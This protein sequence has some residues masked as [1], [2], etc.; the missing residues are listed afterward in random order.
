MKAAIEYAN[1]T[2]CFDYVCI[3]IFIELSHFGTGKMSKVKLTLN[4]V[5]KEVH[6][7]V[8]MRVAVVSECV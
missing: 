2:K 6:I 4:N 7:L 5:S 1:V 3:C 8:G